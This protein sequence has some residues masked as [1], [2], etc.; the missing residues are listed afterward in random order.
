MNDE[1]RAGGDGQLLDY[2]RR[3]TTDLRETRLQ[4]RTLRERDHEPVAIVGMACVYPGGVRSPEGLW[5]LVARGG[6]AIGGFPTDRG[7]DLENLYDTDPDA[8][9]KCSS[10]EGG[11]LSEATLFDAEFFG[12]SP[13]EALTVDPQ[14]RLLLECAWEAFERAGITPG[15]V[16]GT[17]IGTYV[18]VMYN[19]Y[20]SRLQ[21]AP[22]GFEG[23]LGNG[24][25]PSV[26]SGRVAYTLGLEG[27]AVTVDT[28]CSSSLV[29]LHLAV[30]ALRRGECS[31]ALAGGVTVMST[32]GPFIEFSRQRGL[33]PDGRCKA[34]SADADG[35]GW[36]EGAGLLLV[37]RLSDARRNGH[38]V[39]ATVRGSAINQDGASSGLTAPNGPSQERVI[40]KALADAGLRARDI[41]AIEA[42]GTGTTLGDPIEAQ[43]IIAVHGQDREPDRPLYLGSLKSNLGHTQAAAGVGGIIKMVQAMRH[44][45]LPKTLHAEKPNPHIDWSAGTVRLLT[46]ATAWPR[47][48]RPCRAGVSSFGVSGT[49]AHVI[50]EYTPDPSAPAVPDEPRGSALGWPLSATTPAALRDQGARLHHWLLDHPDTDLTAL[51][52]ALNT[53]RTLFKQRAVI[54]ADDKPGLLA[55]LER[56]AAG[57]SGPA[58]VRGEAAVRGGLALMFSGQGSQRPGA[59]QNLSRAFPEFAAEL[60]SVCAHFDPYLDTPLRDVLLAEPGTEA[61]A[62]LDRTAYTQPALFALEVALHRLLERFGVHPGFVTGHSIGEL[63]AAHVAGVWTLEDAAALVAARGRLMQ[64]LPSDG[65]MLAVQAAEEEVLPLLAGRTDRVA[66]AAVNGPE[67]VVVSGDA[68]AVADI[69][70]QA[71][72]KGRRTK[73]LR[74]SNAFHS[75]HMDPVLDAFRA[76]AERI[77]Y[78]PPTIPVVSNLTG[79]AASAAEITDPAYWVEHARRPVRFA[80]GMRWLAEAGVRTFVELGPDS[81]LSSMLP[82]CLTGLPN[83]PTAV[84]LVRRDR[85]EPTSLV[86]ALATLHV[87]GTHVDWTPLFADHPA[88]RA[89]LPTYAFQRHPYWLEATASAP[90]ADAA[91]PGARFWRQACDHGAESA[92]ELLGLSADASLKDVVAA[93]GRY[94]DSAPPAPPHAQEPAADT[95]LAALTG[96]ERRRALLELST[97]VAADVLGYDAPRALDADADLLELGMTSLMAV[98]LRNRLGEALGLELP[99]TLVYDHPVVTEIA[100]FLDEEASR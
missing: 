12:I 22:A 73:L 67:A 10:K 17:D 47:T 59:G 41:D 30:R 46:E 19:D 43:A 5:E 85:P 49:N 44:G 21:P 37:E 65:A 99:P 62:Q 74:T 34:F 18:G 45:V 40:R 88:P 98:E 15:S 87:R 66:I 55:G 93:L 26:A 81:V 13:R 20:A 54:L 27:P 32:P 91:H 56:L 58:L 95:P 16:R 51:A 6:D 72:A 4:L 39:L 78:H 36:G 11:F 2:L 96:E 92:A 83:A 53:D 90:G 89:E 82:G 7:W 29:A 8:L 3:A 25:A 31:M 35:T 71:A 61:A 77:T 1:V 86:T 14:Q 63:V 75:P 76:A 24:S 100:R 28:A 23:F 33:A 80:D 57:E 50:V 84:P 38:P 48:D 94:D 69:G 68:E 42:H 64:Q 97:D 79:R 60:D 9:G 70:R 52:A